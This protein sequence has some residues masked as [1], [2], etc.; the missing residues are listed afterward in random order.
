MALTLYLFKTIKY[1]AYMILLILFVIS[2][3][4]VNSLIV[5]IDTG[6]VKY[7]TIIYMYT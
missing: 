4:F 3:L 1:H 2:V 6:I 5:H 7:I